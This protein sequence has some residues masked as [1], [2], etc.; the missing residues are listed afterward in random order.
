MTLIVDLIDAVIPHR[1]GPGVVTSVRKEVAEIARRFPLTNDAE[2][3][4]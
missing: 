1:G 4:H 3:M 2:G